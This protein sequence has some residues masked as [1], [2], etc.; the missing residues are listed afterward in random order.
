MEF[1]SL[2]HPFTMVVAGPTQSGKSCFVR[3]LLNFKAL[4]FNPSI[5]RV[6]WFY[7]INQPLYDNIENVEFVEGFPS[8]YKEYLSKNTLFIIDD[9]MAE[10]G[11]DPRLTQLF[12]KGVVII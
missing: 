7:G 3:D 1:P 9:L 2:Q 12:T 4:M 11:N 8:N 5:D 6:I 10:C